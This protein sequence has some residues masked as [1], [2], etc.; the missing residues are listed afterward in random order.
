MKSAAQQLNIKGHYGGLIKTRAFIYGPTDIEGHIGT[1]NKYYLLDFA[2]VFPP[3]AEKNVQKTYLYKLFRP[4]FIKNYHI[5][6][7]SDAFSPFGKHNENIHNEEVKDATKYLL[8][9]H[10]PKFAASLNSYSHDID[11]L[12]KLVHREGINIR[13]LGNFSLLILFVKFSSNYFFLFIIY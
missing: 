2:R 4:E 10:I 5:P 13:Y 12:T 1:D 7:S 3:T 8:T 9:E 6:L 11:Q